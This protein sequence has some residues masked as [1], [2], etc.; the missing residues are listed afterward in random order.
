MD[1]DNCENVI[2]VKFKVNQ[3][4]EVDSAG[5]KHV[6]AMDSEAVKLRREEQR[7]KKLERRM[8]GHSYEYVGDFD[9]DEWP[10][11]A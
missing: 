5:G 4:V 9:C 6:H 2:R 3:T 1:T 8:A 7:K 10:P 11:L